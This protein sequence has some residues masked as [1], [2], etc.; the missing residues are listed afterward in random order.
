MENWPSDGIINTKD[1]GL[2][3]V[4]FNPPLTQI[5]TNIIWK[6]GQVFSSAGQF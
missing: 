1:N 2:K 6:K 5:N 3:F 4:P